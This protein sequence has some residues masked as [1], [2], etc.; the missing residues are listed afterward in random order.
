MA[1]TETQNAR[2]LQH[3][4]VFGHITPRE[5]LAIHGVF[6]LAA[7]I[8]QL[9]QAGHEILTQRIQEGNHNFA[10]YVLLKTKTKKRS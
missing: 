6:R 4:K 2:I 9:R 1:E 8:F 10:K 5:A 3:L 7:R